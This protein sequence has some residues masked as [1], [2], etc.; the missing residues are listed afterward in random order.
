MARRDLFL[1]THILTMRVPVKRT[2]LRL[3]AFPYSYSIFSKLVVKSHVSPRAKLIDHGKLHGQTCVFNSCLPYLTKCPCTCG[4]ADRSSIKT[5]HKENTEAVSTSS[6]PSP[7]LLY[8]TLRHSYF[9][10]Y[11][12]ADVDTIKNSMQTQF[13][14]PVGYRCRC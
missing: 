6:S 5:M 10:L 11:E 14:Q 12:F 3:V 2:R 8:P 7:N 1:F 4:N 9:H 13:R